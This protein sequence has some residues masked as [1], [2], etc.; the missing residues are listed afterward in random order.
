M[1]ILSTLG[2]CFLEEIH[3]LKHTTIVETIK[4]EQRKEVKR[5]QGFNSNRKQ[6]PKAV[7]VETCE[8]RD[9]QLGITYKYILLDFKYYFTV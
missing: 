9:S 3:K 4:M 1:T 6:W 8:G 5:N 7:I 2:R